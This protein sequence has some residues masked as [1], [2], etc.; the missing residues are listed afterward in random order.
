MA[1]A[2][3]GWKPVGWLV[4]RNYLGSQLGDQ[5]GKTVIHKG[6]V[7]LIEFQ[8]R[9]WKLHN[10]FPPT[11]RF[12][13]LQHVYVCCTSTPILN[14][15]DDRMSRRRFNSLETTTFLCQDGSAPF[16]GK[17]SSISKHLE[18]LQDDSAWWAEFRHD[19]FFL[20]SYLAVKLNLVMYQCKR[21]RWIKKNLDGQH[22][23]T[24]MQLLNS[25][26]VEVENY[27]LR[28][29]YHLTT[30]N[31]RLNFELTWSISWDSLQVAGL[32]LPG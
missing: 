12:L 32:V 31:L 4:D 8:K 24:P 18:K 15:R 5:E 16:W 11:Q 1:I 9:I 10:L 26:T 13:G 27:Q 22:S 14:W 17:C 30:S 7:F 3:L 21:L 29:E 25:T 2:G 20:Y 19:F 6:G 23:Y 28:W